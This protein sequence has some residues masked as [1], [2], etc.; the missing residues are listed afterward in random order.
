M[1][2]DYGALTWDFIREAYRSPADLCIV[3][4][5]DYLVKGREARLN[6]PG[7]SQGN[8]QWRMI[9]DFLSDD[10]ALSIKSLA[11]TYGR[12]VEKNINNKKAVL[13]D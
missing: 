11:A 9:P 12:I 8:W 10:L 5:Q 1:N 6:M 2:T 3:P 13:T 7:T 4:I